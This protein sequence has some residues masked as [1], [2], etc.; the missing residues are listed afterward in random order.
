MNVEKNLGI[1]IIII[2]VICGGI[3]GVFSGFYLGAKSQTEEP[4]WTQENNPIA[5]ES[6]VGEEL[7]IEKGERI[8]SEESVELEAFVIPDITSIQVFV[9]TWEELIDRTSKG[10]LEPEEASAMIYQLSS[11]GYRRNI[12]QAYGVL[13]LKEV[14]GKTMGDLKDIQFSEPSYE[15]GKTVAVVEVKERFEKGE[16]TYLLKLIKEKEHWYFAAQLSR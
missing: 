15:N 5:V 9:D 3:V 11:E 10:V 13:R 8:S 2:T 4:S 14:I 6:E 16:N 12:P 1:I 7:D